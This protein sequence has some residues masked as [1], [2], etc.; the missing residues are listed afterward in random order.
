[1]IFRLKSNAILLSHDNL[2][3]CNYRTFIFYITIDTEKTYDGSSLAN[4]SPW[5]QREP[6]PFL[7]RV[8]E[9]RRGFLK[10]D[11]V[12]NYDDFSGRKWPDFN[13]F[14]VIEPIRGFG[15]DRETG[16]PPNPHIRH[17]PTTNAKI[18]HV[19]SNASSL[20][21]TP[22]VR[23]RFGPFDTVFDLCGPTVKRFP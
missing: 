1:M 23:R 15:P 18:Y 16:K 3:P 6:D 8:A 7:D 14:P 10:S 22:I 19:V 9:K 2:A 13:R 20:P 17:K 11:V 12:K 4:S 5:G 21:N